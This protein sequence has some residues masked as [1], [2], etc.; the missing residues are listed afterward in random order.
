MKKA[1]VITLFLLIFIMQMQ[2]EQITKIGVIN[3]SKI[4][5]YFFRESE[6]VRDLELKKTEFESEIQRLGDNIQRLEDQ[7]LNAESR[8]DEA[9]VLQLDNQIFSQSQYLKDYIRIKNRQL[10][11]MKDQLTSS[12]SFIRE[13][14][15]EVEY[16]AESEGYSLILD[17][18]DPNLF[19]WIDQIDITE[20]VIE[21]LSTKITE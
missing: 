20:L 7:K 1:Q 15:Q 2:A 9:L 21:R 3:L 12:E 8:G 19:F 14:Q 11:D 10:Q 18:K 5:T 4:Y 17:I 16:V 13:I 6:T